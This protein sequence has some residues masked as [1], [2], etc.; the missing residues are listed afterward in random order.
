MFILIFT[1]LSKKEPQQH[2]FPAS[3][4]RQNISYTQ[5]VFNKLDESTFH[6]YFMG[7]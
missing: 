2:M 7:L 1:V 6:A 5:V 4:G 3:E